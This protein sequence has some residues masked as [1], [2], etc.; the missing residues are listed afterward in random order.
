MRCQSLELPHKKSNFANIRCL[1]KNLT[2]NHKRKQEELDDKKRETRVV[3]EGETTLPEGEQEREELDTGRVCG[4]HKLQPEICHSLAEKWNTEKDEQES[5]SET[6][7]R[8][9]RECCTGD[10]LGSEWSFVWQAIE[11]LHAGDG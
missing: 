3:E 1:I 4:E 6:Q 9:R 10:R 8:A 11:A 7:I 5:W 2:V